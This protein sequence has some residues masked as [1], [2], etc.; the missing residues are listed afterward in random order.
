MEVLKGYVSRIVFR[1]ENNAYTVFELV[2]GTET[3]T[4][5]GII[6]S[7]T[8]GESCILSGRMVSHPVY[9]E[10]FHTETYEACAPEGLQ[11][12]Q[13]YLSSG[14]V[15]GV[16]MAL[17][18]RI[19]K[20]F[21]DDTMRVL[22]EEPERLCE[23]KGISERMAREI[24]AQLEGRKDLR[25]ALVFMEGYGLRGQ[26]ALDIY[27]TYG[28]ELYTV[29]R[30]YPYR[31]YY[32]IDGIGFAK[33]D[34]I[35]ARTGAVTDPD[36]R[37]RAALVYILTLALG[38]GNI[39]LPMNELV[40]ECMKLLSAG[41]DED[42]I[43]IQASNMAMDGRL[44]IRR[45]GEVYLRRCWLTEQEIAA[46]LTM[47]D[48]V[49]P[50]REE[51]RR[52][53]RLTETVL[54]E[55]ETV[56]DMEQE[57]ALRYAAE[58]TVLLIT[59]GPGTGK[60]T[61]INAIIRMFVRA[62]MDVVLAAPTGRAAHRMS[63]ATG[64][65]ASTLHRLLGVRPD[66]DAA[67]TSFEKD[68]D[69]PLEA[70]AVIVDEMSMVDEFIFHALLKA[71]R[72]GT[73]LI[74]VG[75]TDQ[76]PSV[77]PGSVLKDIIGSGRFAC[78]RLEHVFR[79]AAQSGIVMNAHRILEGKGTVLD[80]KSSDFFFLKRND[81]A[82]I[83]KHMVE[84][85]RD[86]L[87]AWLGCSPGDIQILTPM[88]KGPLGAVRLN[89]VLQSVLNPEDRRK[90]EIRYGE[91]VFRVGDK[92]MQTR[93][94]YQL[95]YEKRGSTGFPTETGTGIYNGDF[96]V[97]EDIDRAAGTLT[98]RFDDDRIV[99]YPV[100]S[101]ED[102]ELAYAIT[103]H[104][105]QGSEYTAVLLPLMPGPETLFN[106]NLLYT[107]VTRAREAVVILGDEN[108]IRSMENNTAQNIRYTGLMQAIADCIG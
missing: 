25:E 51:V 68:E 38:D 78:V 7:L 62:G 45:E 67:G 81:P 76:L 26:A 50:D 52:L 102:L 17:A 15:K 9:G 43:R 71:L 99:D 44:V 90:A 2:Q 11:A 49:R 82:V 34:E 69:E 5:T 104:K 37:I 61:G 23:I 30:H 56:P 3:V 4:C 97:I 14:A 8:E 58:R 107:A 66:R 36:E 21:G 85:K 86:R 1:N 53:K 94:D 16:G 88:K 80:N 47:L 72:P 42:S 29:I 33:A 57:E 35:A 108:T 87:P 91:S 75:D 93:N 54:C 10:Q 12:V 65:E 89:R 59:G 20:A 100:Q 28:S 98:I 27:R 41:A 70:D 74:M 31:L 77:G 22:D 48:S 92:V 32:E 103:V 73:R 95:A 84:L 60:T 96:G 83:Y 46:R 6:A 39:Y 55:E 64:F 79:Q 19:V 105:S 63:E 106:R 24:A 13:R 101:L 18:E 40:Q